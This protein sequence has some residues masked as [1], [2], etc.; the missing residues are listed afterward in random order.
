MGTN[1]SRYRAWNYSYIGRCDAIRHRRYCLGVCLLRISSMGEMMITEEQRKQRVRFIGSSDIAALFTDESGK[2]LDPFKTAA[3]VWALKAFEHE[4]L[5]KETPSISIGHR[6]EDACI[7]FVKQ[8]IGVSILTDPD[9]MRFICPEH[10]IFAANLD[11]YTTSDFEFDGERVIGENVIV[12][13]KTT[14]MAN[15]WGEPGTDEV[16]F[17]V[18]LQVH[19]QML[20]TGWNKAIIVVLMGRWGLREELYYV[21]RNEKII[22]AII[23]RGEQF[24]NNHVLTKTPPPD[25]EPGDIRIFKKIVRHPKTVADVPTEL[26]HDWE[27]VRSERLESEKKEKAL[28]AEILKHLGDAEGAQ[29]NDGRLFTYFKQRGADSIDRKALKEQY[30]DVYAAVAKESFHR[31]PRIRKAE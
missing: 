24:W 28:F 21:R 27:F 22:K 1:V 19:H 30:P 23:E 6:H 10:Q 29:L 7:E 15:E 16:P 25:A 4:D 12:E 14:G 2:S 3:D 31:T 11:G 5:H 26:I 8:T 17:R 13:A 18:L 20:C 9:A